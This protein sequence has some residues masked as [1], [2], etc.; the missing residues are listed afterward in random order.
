MQR[1]AMLCDRRPVDERTIGSV[2]GQLVHGRCTW[3][4]GITLEAYIRGVDARI[5][6]EE[7]SDTPFS[8]AGCGEMQCCATVDLLMNEPL[9]QYGANWSMAGVLGGGHARGLHPWR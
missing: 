5:G 6:L 4:E 2:R 7:E 1:D 9:D 8:V 3:G